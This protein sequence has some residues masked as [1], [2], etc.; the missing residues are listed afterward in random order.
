MKKILCLLFF[1]FIISITSNSSAKTFYTGDQVKDYFI[2]NNDNSNNPH[3]KSSH[4]LEKY[5]RSAKSHGFKL[6]KEFDQTEN[7]MPTLD[8]G[9]YF[10]KRFINPILEYGLYSAKKN[11]PKSTLMIQKIIKKVTKEKAILSTTGGTSDA[12]FI[13]KISPCLEFGLVGKTMHKIDEAVSLNDLRNLT[14]IYN[15]ILEEFFIIK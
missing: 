11:Y 3:L 4:D 2:Y 12:R 14:K 8:Y 15:Q 10:I 6:I 1:S 7:T 13:R 9:D 5:L